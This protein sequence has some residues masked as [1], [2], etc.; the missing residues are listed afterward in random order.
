[1]YYGQCGNGECREMVVKPVKLQRNKQRSQDLSWKG[2]DQSFVLCSHT[3]LAEL[4]SRTFLL[5]SNSGTIHDLSCFVQ[6]NG[7]KS[8]QKH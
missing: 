8:E 2:H 3:A 5:V 1:M 7:Q 6:G 4:R